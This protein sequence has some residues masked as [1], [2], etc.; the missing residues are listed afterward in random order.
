MA[1]GTASYFI[2]Q[3][4]HYYDNTTY[5]YLTKSHEFTKTI[6]TSGSFTGASIGSAVNAANDAKTSANSAKSSADAAKAEATAAKN[7]AATAA[8]RT[9]Y[10]SKSAAQWAAEG[11]SSA[12]S[13]ATAA[14]NAK[15]A[16]DTAKSEA[17]AAK[18][19]A[20]TA[21]AR[22]WDTTESKS[23]ATLAKEARDKANENYTK[24][25]SLENSITNIENVLATADTIPPTIMSIK[26][27]K[28]ATCTTGSSFPV[29]VEASDNS[30]GVLEFRVKETGTTNWSEWV[31]ITTYNT[32]SGIVGA[33][34]IE[35]TVE[36][37]DSAG[38]VS[39]GSMTFFRL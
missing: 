37:R 14:N 30:G 27:Y 34:A 17:T 31:P 28:G 26:G 36:V 19:N 21:A 16:A 9:I 25:Q 15:T 11:K 12:D 24:L 35:V 2:K 8:S 5:T 23:A 4:Y 20:G 38:N 18:N 3:V 6:S 13:A 33:G 1:T 29:T 10:N 22:V 7:N 39:T 32:V